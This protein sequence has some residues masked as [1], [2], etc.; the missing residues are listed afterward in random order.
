MK[1]KINKIAYL[2]TVKFPAHVHILILHMLK[3]NE[4]FAVI[5]KDKS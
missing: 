5:K 2:I 1:K 4:Y 3:H